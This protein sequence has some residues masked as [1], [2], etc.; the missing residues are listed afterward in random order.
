[1]L[2]CFFYTNTQC[3]Y[4]PIIAYILKM[5]ENIELLKHGSKIKTIN[6]TVGSCTA[7]L[8]RCLGS[9]VAVSG[10]VAMIT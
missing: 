7:C 10:N 6:S 2:E 4:T 1:M 9:L 8:I 5:K 3:S